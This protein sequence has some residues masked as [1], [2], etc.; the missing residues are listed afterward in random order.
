MAR[1]WAVI[2]VFAFQS[3]VSSSG[4]HSPPFGAL[5]HRSFTLDLWVARH[6]PTSTTA[7]HSQT[8]ADNKVARKKSPAQPE[9]HTSGN[10]LTGTVMR[11]PGKL[12]WDGLRVHPGSRVHLD[13]LASMGCN[14]L[15]V[16]G[17]WI[18]TGWAE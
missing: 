9:I 11:S 18:A 3:L 14:A 12:F 5:N 2:S 13:L 17:R 4:G 8:A 7:F 1:Q 10:G 6:K 15:A 16:F